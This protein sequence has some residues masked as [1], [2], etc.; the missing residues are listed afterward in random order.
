MISEDI[1]NVTKAII[2]KNARIKPGRCKTCLLFVT[3]FLTYEA[4]FAQLPFWTHNDI[5][6]MNEAPVFA[7]ESIAIRASPASQLSSWYSTSISWT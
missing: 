6:G 1:W 5:I 3:A 2:Y 7:K 4:I